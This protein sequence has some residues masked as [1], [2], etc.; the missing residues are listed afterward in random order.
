MDRFVYHCAHGA[1]RVKTTCDYCADTDFVLIGPGSCV[2]A[3]CDDHEEIA[4]RDMRASLYQRGRVLWED[5][6]ESLRLT[7]DRGYPAKLTVSASASVWLVRVRGLWRT[8][9]KQPALEFMLPKRR[10]LR[11][12]S[13]AQGPQGARCLADY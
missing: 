10:F 9:T 8:Q 2:V 13:G 6:P 12:K 3:T 5:L 7:V 1:G 11:C 4:H